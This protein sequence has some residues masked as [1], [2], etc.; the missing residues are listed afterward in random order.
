MTKRFSRRALLGGWLRGGATAAILSALC[1][2]I[3]PAVAARPAVEAPA[4]A[5]AMV[6]GP[7]AQVAAQLAA[8][9]PLE[10]VRYAAWLAWGEIKRPALLLALTGDAEPI[11]RA[12]AAVGLARSNV[13][14]LPLMREELAQVIPDERLR[15]QAAR[16]VGALAWAV[17]RADRDPTA[18]FLSNYRNSAPDDLAGLVLTSRGARATPT[19]ARWL[20]RG[21]AEEQA[22]AIA[23]AGLLGPEASP[24]LPLLEARLMR[25]PA[26]ES[27]PLVEAITAMGP[28]AAATLTRLLQRH[29]IAAVR[30]AIAE[31]SGLDQEVMPGLAAA[32]LTDV[33][34]DVRSAARYAL[35]D[36][37]REW[38]MSAPPLPRE[39]APLVLGALDE[40]RYAFENLIRVDL[41]DKDRRRAIAWLAHSLTAAVDDDEVPDYPVGLARTL[42]E[43]DGAGAASQQI[44]LSAIET[45]LPR[46]PGTAARLLAELRASAPL[47]GTPE[48]PARIWQRAAADDEDAEWG[49][50]SALAGA[51]VRERGQLPARA[52]ALQTPDIRRREF[53]VAGLVAAGA[54][55]Q[56]LLTRA[57]ASVRNGCDV[58]VA[59]VAVVADWPLESGS[60]PS[61]PSADASAALT[62]W[63]R[64]CPSLARAPA[65]DAA[66]SGERRADE[67]A[68]R[69]DADSIRQALVTGDPAA[70]RPVIEQL[71]ADDDRLCMFTRLDERFTPVVVERIAQ[72]G[73]NGFDRLPCAAQ[74]AAPA[75]ALLSAL[76]DDS[77]PAALGWLTTD[78]EDADIEGRDK[79]LAALSVPPQAGAFLQ[80]QRAILRRLAIHP[81][82][83]VRQWAYQRRSL[84]GGTAIDLAVGLDD[85]ELRVATAAAAALFSAESGPARQRRTA[86]LLVAG[87]GLAEELRRFEE[88]AHEELVD[89]LPPDGPEEEIVTTSNRIPA[90]PVLPWP[91]PRWTGRVAFGV[92]VPGDLLGRP[93]HRLDVVHRRLVRALRKVDASF[94]TGLFGVPGGFA[95]VARMEQTNEDGRPLAGADRWRD[96]RPGPA[97]FAEFA[98]RLFLAPPGFYRVVVFLVTD[99]PNFGL[100]DTALPAA[101]TGGAHLPSDISAVR[102]RDRYGFAL[103]YSFRK[104]DGFEFEPHPVVGGLAHL[105]RAGIITALQSQ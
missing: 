87:R 85:P 61:L 54:D 31:R 30:E 14:I 57:A 4:G 97:T 83:V 59:L 100:S 66:P 102:L 34:E 40:E 94:D 99:Q 74:L 62:A 53:R 89:N 19:L 69:A 70:L 84:D 2:T 37:D 63:A 35:L 64:A 33:D 46:N 38:E 98:T 41:D 56:R 103:I 71:E 20:K 43:I 1:V 78:G 21:T 79:V 16:R 22:A 55:G 29:P 8:L 32:A 73:W 23:A 48:L 90:L 24:L 39:A 49:V 28:G 44:L 104:R 81:I 11:V 45:Y 47:A 17:S 9:P 72:R 65:D 91:P 77:D 50:T 96:I 12:H 95:V 25:A 51:A 88:A 27:E 36:T 86:V 68:A 105:Q 52:N 101:G 82:P 10:R 18:E 75:A 60:E 13:D 92:D 93:D 26:D 3:D 67:D 7:D 80:Q 42:L 5:A 15:R 58:F 6:D 76:I